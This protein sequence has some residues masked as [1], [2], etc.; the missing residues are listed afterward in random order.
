MFW[1]RQLSEQN[2]LKMIHFFSGGTIERAA[3]GRPLVAHATPREQ[4]NREGTH[5]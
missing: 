1:Q 3:G 2:F 5:R 4:S